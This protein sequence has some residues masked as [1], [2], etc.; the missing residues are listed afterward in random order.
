[1]DLEDD[2]LF[3]SCRTRSK[4]KQKQ[5][6]HFCYLQAKQQSS[7]AYLIFNVYIFFIIYHF[8]SHNFSVSAYRINHP[9]GKLHWSL[10][11]GLF[12]VNIIR[13]FI[14][15]SFI[16][17]SSNGGNDSWGARI[18][19]STG[20]TLSS[21]VEQSTAASRRIESASPSAFTSHFPRLL[22][23]EEEGET[24]DS[25]ADGGDDSS[26][27]GAGFIPTPPPYRPP[28]YT[29]AMSTRYR[30]PKSGGGSGGRSSPKSNAFIGDSKYPSMMP[31]IAKVLFESQSSQ[32]ATPRPAGGS[33]SSSRKHKHG[34]RAPKTAAQ[35][36]SYFEQYVNFDTPA[37]SGVGATTPETGDRG[38]PES[39]TES[40]ESF[41]TDDFFNRPYYESTKPTKPK[42]R[43]GRRPPHPP[44]KYHH[45]F[46][47]TLESPPAGGTGGEGATYGRVIMYSTRTHPSPK[48]Q[49][50]NDEEPNHWQQN[51]RGGGGEKPAT[52]SS[53]SSSDSSDELFVPD[54]FDGFNF[55]KVTEG[56]PPLDDQ[57]PHSRPYSKH[58]S[59][60]FNNKF[61][62]ANSV[63]SGPNSYMTLSYE[64]LS[65]EQKSSL[66]KRRP[67]STSSIK[68]MTTFHGGPYHGQPKKAHKPTRVQQNEPE[69][70]PLRT[71]E[72][73]PSLVFR[74]QTEHPTMSLK[75]I[76]DQQE[77]PDADSDSDGDE[78][79]STVDPI[80]QFN[81][82]DTYARRG[83]HD[84]PEVPSH[85]NRQSNNHRRKQKRTRTPL[86]AADTYNF[87]G[88]HRHLTAQQP[89]MVARNNYESPTRASQPSPEWQ[90]Q[91]AQAEP[92]VAGGDDN[93]LQQQQQPVKL[94]YYRSYRRRDLPLSPDSHLSGESTTNR[95]LFTPEGESSTNYPSYPSSE[96]PQA[97]SSSQLEAEKYDFSESVKKYAKEFGFEVPTNDK[98]NQKLNNNKEGGALASNAA[99][100]SVAANSNHRASLL[101][102]DQPQSQSSSASNESSKSD[103]HYYF[104]MLFP[105]FSTEF[106]EKHQNPS[107]AEGLQLLS[108][109]LEQQSSDDKTPQNSQKDDEKKG[110]DDFRSVMSTFVAMVGDETITSELAKPVT[111]TAAAASPTA[112]K[113]NTSGAGE[114]QLS[115][116]DVDAILLKFNEVISSKEKAAA[117]EASK[118]DFDEADLH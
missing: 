104:N 64:P 33:G 92:E 66:G 86:K 97:A 25:S 30:G 70:A 10:F 41:K 98:D 42:P 114:N 12:F 69:Y 112:E 38:A 93:G 84:A 103:S 60:S 73:T 40:P 96:Q 11:F 107:R 55:E 34:N 78:P 5:K 62:P 59:S 91:Q 71:E 13:I 4:S 116:E 32:G 47:T 80:L 52:T 46:E 20:T 115:K 7:L 54:D 50:E 21:T 117:V 61:N 100:A 2:H 29:E 37:N 36:Q 77:S 3:S 87:E 65:D 88:S 57:P 45:K 94:T 44:K 39:G 43:S 109:S 67:V 79:D 53:S 18:L 51:G 101:S 95:Y 76:E 105:E 17:S 111:K 16:Y 1:M 56:S 58:K 81:Y 83:L 75:D 68:P 6:Q 108:S 28:I 113:T 15:N 31:Q 26:D 106:K 49:T 48:P 23:D 14:G 118:L 72:R 110:A 9:K 24:D 82:V 8:S 35:S 63:V 102:S 19:P 90:R 89:E 74:T 99:S 85:Y 27:S 22:N